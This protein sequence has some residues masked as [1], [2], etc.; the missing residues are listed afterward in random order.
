MFARFA[1]K[2]PVSNAELLTMAKAVPSWSLPSGHTHICMYVY[3]YIYIYIDPVAF[4][5]HTWLKLMW[6]HLRKKTPNAMS[7]CDGCGTR[8]TLN[9]RRRFLGL[10][11]VMRRRRAIEFLVWATILATLQASNRQWVVSNTEG[12][13]YRGAFSFS[14]SRRD[15]PSSAL[16]RRRLEL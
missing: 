2:I 9:G 3:I 1:F 7:C 12:G 11:R 15:V 8:T 10:E 16:V 13:R 4:L 6:R 14:M 5:R